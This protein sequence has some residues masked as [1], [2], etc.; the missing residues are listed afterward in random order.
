M[1]LA[2]KRS[3]SPPKGGSRREL[4]GA[5]PTE[6]PQESSSGNSKSSLPSRHN[7][8]LAALVVALMIVAGGVGL[9]FWNRDESA[10]NALVASVPSFVGST[11]CAGCHQAEAQLWRGSHH[12]QAMDHATQAS[13]LGDFN[14]ASFEHHGVRSRF[15][16]QDGKFLVETDG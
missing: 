3:K 4:A 7:I 10:D 9:P 11:A 15:F 2:G 12:E 5:R 1:T 16:R 8:W 13:V 14:D 6:P